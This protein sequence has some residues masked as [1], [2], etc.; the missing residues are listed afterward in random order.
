MFDRWSIIV[1]GGA[2]SIPPQ[3][4]ERNRAGCRDAAVIGDGIL[5]DGGT[6]LDATLA[7]VMALENDPTF[8]AGMG[9]VPN[10]EGGYELDA[11]IMEGTHLNIGAVAGLTGVH[12]PVKIARMLLDEPPVLL[13][14]DGARSFA[15]RKGIVLDVAACEQTDLQFPGM[16]HDTVGCIA[17]DR[18]GKMAVA[19]STGGLT[20]QWPGR[21]GDAPLAGCGFYV[22]DVVGGVAISGDGESI[23]RVILASRVMRALESHSPMQATRNALA[24]LDRVGGEAGIIA[25]GKDGRL[26]VAYNSPQFAIAIANH[27]MSEP[28]A[29]VEIQEYEDVLNDE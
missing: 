2:R 1:H 25:L 9:S 6:A 20:D 19:T 7:V 10:A 26:G 11:A 24:S 28:R 3:Q 27:R 15:A 16:Q 29:G 22:D 8:N 17:L 14:G 12:N 4:H 18:F 21:V 5:R 13:V 23:V